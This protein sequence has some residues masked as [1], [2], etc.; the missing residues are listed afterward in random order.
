MATIDLLEW[1]SLTAAINKA[2]TPESFV[3]DRVFRTRQQHLSNKVDI[4]IYDADSEKLAQFAKP[5][6]MAVVVNKR[7]RRL[8]TITI[9]ETREKKYFSAQELGTARV[10]VAD[11]MYNPASGDLVNY[12]NDV[13]ARETAA[14]RNRIIRRMEQLA[15]AA[16]QG[17]V[18]VSQPNLEFSLDFGYQNGRQLVAL[19]GTSKWD[20]TGADIIEDLLS[21]D[22]TITE[23]TSMGASMVVLGSNAARYLRSNDKVIKRLDSINYR[24]GVVDLTQSASRAGRF[25][26]TLNNLPLF[27]YNQKYAD[28]TGTV[29]DMVNPNSVIVVSESDTFRLHLGAMYREEGVI[30]QQFFART[31]SE[32]DPDGLW[33][34][35]ASAFLPVTHDPDCVICATVL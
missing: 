12:R 4:E 32:K 27:E 3:L 15:C 28:A 1:R 8:Q 21:W 7:N 16:L 26:G 23:R 29:R 30:T 20:Q 17:N 14:L 25:L 13:L 2:Q 33:L 22:S 10:S 11:G 24:N 6:E 5:E 19:A 31:R 34:E 9:P 35:L 18:T